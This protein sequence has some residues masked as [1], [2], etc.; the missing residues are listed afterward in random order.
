MQLFLVVKQQVTELV[1]GREILAH[2][3]MMGIHSDDCLRRV[4]EEETG[5]IVIKGLIVDSCAF[6]LGDSLDRHRCFSDL[7][8]RKQLFDKRLNLPSSDSHW[9]PPSPRV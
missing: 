9:F 6:G 1:R 2:S 8:G 5:H 7:V 3:R 4:S